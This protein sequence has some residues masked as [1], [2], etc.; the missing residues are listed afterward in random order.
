MS[1]PRILYT[2]IP[3]SDKTIFDVQAYLALMK[4][5]FVESDAHYRRTGYQ[6]EFLPSRL[7]NFA[8]TDWLDLTGARLILPPITS[9]ASSTGSTH[10]TRPTHPTN[11]IERAYKRQRI[12]IRFREKMNE[13]DRTRELDSPPVSDDDSESEEDSTLWEMMDPSL[14]DDVY[15]L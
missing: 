1:A 8:L 10:P 7:R 3:R 2:G 9:L 15:V 4:A 11:P 14:D 13:L 6:P 5:T 12:G